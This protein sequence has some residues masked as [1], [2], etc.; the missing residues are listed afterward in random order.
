MNIHKELI[1]KIILRRDSPL[2]YILDGEDS[3]NLSKLKPNI[4]LLFYELD[5]I[6]YTIDFLEKNSLIK[7]TKLKQNL[8]NNFFDG[9]NWTS[10]A[11]EQSHSLHYF[12]EKLRKED[13]LSWQIEALPGLITFKNNGYQT[14]EQLKEDRN[15]FVAITVAILSSVLTSLLK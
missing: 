10:I 2:A 4:S 15:F 14:D 11:L 7:I 8:G 5:R 3:L 9:F 12:Y 13:M 1:K 6:F